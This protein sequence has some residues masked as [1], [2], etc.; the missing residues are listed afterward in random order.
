M[1]LEVCLPARVVFARGAIDRLGEL[2]APWGTRAAL[3]RGGS[4]LERFGT[5]ERVRSQLNAVGI[6]CVEFTFVGEPD[7]IAVD[8]A[9][10]LARKHACDMVVGLGGGAVLDAAKA[11]SGLLSLGGEALDY[12]EVV[13]R[14]KPIAAACAPMIAIPT[15]AGTGTEVTRNAVLTH[16]SSR[17]KASMRSVHLIARVA[18]VDPQLTDSVPPRVTA[19]TGLDALTQLIEPFVSTGAN[20]WT[21]GISLQGVKLAARALPKAWENGSDQAAR[22]DM[23]LA[24]LMGGVCLAH[25][26]LGVVHGFAAPLGAMFPI[27]H[28][29]ACA[30][31]LVPGIEANVRALR[32]LDRAHPTLARFAQLGEILT[33]KRFATPQEAVDATVDFV[34]DLVQKL[35]VPTLSS[36]G[37]SASDTPA[38]VAAAKKASSMRYNPVVLSDQ[39]L[40]QCFREAL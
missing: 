27:P 28:G 15:T 17:F 24:S 1:K 21:D 34:R 7:T 30:A 8:T 26:G 40:E 39:A 4:H 22:D 20:P 38:V 11:V 9:T 13:G 25:A 37:V 31:L 14:G 23:A 10:Q 18:L 36:F 6:D 19:S 29:A 3:V 35:Q 32:Q 16:K 5:L 12:L 33:E 2:A